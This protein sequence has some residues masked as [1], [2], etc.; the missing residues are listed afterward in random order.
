MRVNKI[1]V[2]KRE[3]LKAKAKPTSMPII[4]LFTVKMQTP[5]QRISKH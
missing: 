5:M 1:V 4:R 2:E 3:I